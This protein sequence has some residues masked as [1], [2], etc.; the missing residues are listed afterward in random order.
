M[1]L[2]IRAV[3]AYASRFDDE[4]NPTSTP[5]Q[6]RPV[7]FGGDRNPMAVHDQAIGL[8]LHC[9]R[10]V[11]IVAVMPKQVGIGRRVNQIVDRHKLQ[12][13]MPLE[14]CLE[15]LSPNPPKSID[16]EPHCNVL[17]PGTPPATNL[18]HLAR[19]GKISQVEASRMPPRLL[20]API[21]CANRG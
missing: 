2:R 7:A 8:D 15:G 9:S 18:F 5:V 4:I 21:G 3:R 11:P 16:A 12:R 20:A 14:D 13:R 1:L 19:P 17:P 10:E 6:L